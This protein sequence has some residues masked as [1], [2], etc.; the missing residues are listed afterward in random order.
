MQNILLR[1]R[2]QEVL[3]S[4][5]FVD[6]TKKDKTDKG[7]KIIPIINNL[8]ESFKAVFSNKPEQSVDKQNSKGVPQWGNT[9]K[10]NL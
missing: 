9:W 5:H 7:D 4:L 8:N 2:Y 3:Q 6:N 10:W 1:T